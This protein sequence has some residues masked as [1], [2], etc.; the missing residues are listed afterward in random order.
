MFVCPKCGFRDDPCWKAHR[1]FLYAVY[2]RLDE[3]E[4]FDK[5]LADKLRETPDLEI[6]PY[7]YHVTSPKNPDTARYVLRIPNDL[8]EFMYR[9]ELIERYKQRM[10]PFQKKLQLE[11]AEK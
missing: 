9:R 11:K 7:A 3:L 5:E 8:K 2:C 6:G 1:Y 10:D 4:V